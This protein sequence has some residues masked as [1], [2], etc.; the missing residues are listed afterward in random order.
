MRRRLQLSLL[1]IGIAACPAFVEADELQSYDDTLM[2]D[3]GGW[4]SRLRNDGVDL[5]LSYTTETA[6]NVQG[7]AK[8]GVR[9]TDQW[10][11]GATLDLQKLLRLND[12]V[13]QISITDRNGRNL[14]AD[15]HLDALQL[16]QEVYGRGQTW[17]ITQFWYDQSYFDKA[18]DWKIGRLTEGGDFASFSCYFQNLTFCGAPPG[19]LVGNYWYNWPVSQWA[20]RV[21]VAVPNFGYVQLGAYEVNPSYLQRAYAFDPGDPPGATGALIPFEAAWLPIFGQLA[22]SY[23]FGAWYNT[24]STADAVLNTQGQLLALNGGQPLMRNGAYGA[25]INFLQ[26][27]TPPSADE[28]DRGLSAFFNATVADR[29][30]AS[31]DSQ[32]AVGIIYGGPLDSRPK[33]DI[34]LAFGRTH[35]NDRVAEAEELQNAAGLGPVPVQHSEYATEL[36]YTIHLTDWLNLRP[37]LQYIHEPGGIAQTDDIILGLKTNLNF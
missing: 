37:N 12:A 7:G 18:V 16:V 2:G 33:D 30:T 9:Y 26:R 6:S 21:K 10:T 25:Y 17:R 8:V 3:W 20:S 34:G 22:G 32:I 28:P 15:E 27:L 1:A 35:V 14:V 31:V 23:K 4:R 13:L 36:Y 11:L 24:S 29:R 5:T 19:N